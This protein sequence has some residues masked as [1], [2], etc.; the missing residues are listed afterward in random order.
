[1]QTYI[2]RIKGATVAKHLTAFPA[3][4]LIGARQVGKSTLAKNN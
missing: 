1:M 3:V 2:P 4:V